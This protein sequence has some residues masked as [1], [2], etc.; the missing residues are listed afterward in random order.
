MED[1]NNSN[2]TDATDSQADDQEVWVVDDDII[3]AM[4]EDGD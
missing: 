1:P 3:E 2:W 4:N